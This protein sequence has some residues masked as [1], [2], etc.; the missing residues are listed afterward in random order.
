[1]AITVPFY[2]WDAEQ[3]EYS[4]EGFEYTF[5]QMSPDY[6][7]KI[8]KG[9]TGNEGVDYGLFIDNVVFRGSN[10]LSLLA[11]G[12]S[13][14]SPFAVSSEHFYMNST[15]E[16]QDTRKY[17]ISD[18]LY[19][20]VYVTLLIRPSLTT[21]Q[22]KARIDMTCAIKFQS[23]IRSDY[24][25]LTATNLTFP[26]I[27]YTFDEYIA[28]TSGGHP[29]SVFIRNNYIWFMNAYP[30]SKDLVEESKTTTGCLIQSVMIHQA[31]NSPLGIY[32]Y[33]HD[34]WGIQG[35]VVQP[36]NTH[37]TYQFYVPEILGY[38]YEPEFPPSVP[39]NKVGGYDPD[40]DMGTFPDGPLQNAVLSGMV[41]LYQLTTT[42][43]KDFAK[44]LW[45]TDLTDWDN[46]INTIKQWFSNP[47]DS[48]ISLTIN[49]VDVFGV[50]RAGDIDLP[51][52]SNIKIAN[53]D[54]G[55]KGYLCPNNIKMVPMGAIS[56]SPFYNSFLD[57]NPHTKFSLFLPYIGFKD[58]DADVIFSKTPSHIE[59]EYLVDV[60]TGVC[61]ANIMIEK[62]SNGTKLKHIIYTF[63][64]N[65]NTVI[66]ISSAN[67]RDFMSATVGAVA[68][69][70]AVA[71][72]GGTLTPVIAGSMMAQQG[73]NI[74]SQKIN[75]A[76]SGGMSLEGGSFS[77]Q[78]AY[79]IVQRPREA[80]PDNYMEVNGLPSEISGTIGQ[81]RGF[82][83]ISSGIININGA[84]DSEKKEI[85]QLLKEGIIV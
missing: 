13:E 58:I 82:T 85:E 62:E 34:M 43:M 61:T 51:N 69:T 81:F 5:G 8:A 32:Q 80:R 36:T 35:T 70:L 2:P 25:T 14:L 68:S 60:I 73:L 71:G 41:R 12:N 46:F 11:G 54:T 47:L 15:T 4:E 40:S 42:Q 23:T 21:E 84:T 1:M 64:G 79:L 22:G 74:A 29:L 6:Y 66:P 9:S 18:T 48:I 67:M 83:Q 19:A 45:S 65:T 78:Y 30:Y 16:L 17:K 72:S 24:F 26:N 39:D 52:E 7:N 76:H 50:Y 31:K 63:S 59:I 38:G 44:F 37:Q 56:L 27:F 75:I 49:P 20:E 53:Y 55:V 77:H 57:C 10:I 3:Q 33:P 28:E